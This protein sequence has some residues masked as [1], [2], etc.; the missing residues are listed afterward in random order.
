MLHHTRLAAECLPRVG[1]AVGGVDVRLALA[2]VAEPG[3]LHDRSTGDGGPCR[4]E[5]AGV[6]DHSE[7]ADGEARL[8]EEPL[9]G[10]PVLHDGDGVWPGANQHA[11]AQP[12]QGR[13][14]RILELDRHHGALL[15]QPVDR[16]RVV[17]GGDEMHIG[18]CARRGGGIGFEHH[19]AVPHRARRDGEIPAQLAAAEDADGGGR[20]DRAQAHPGRVGSGQVGSGQVGGRCDDTAASC[21]SAR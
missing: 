17:V 21:R 4:G 9:L 16:R 20:G 19:R 8:A 11:A 14:G 12:L 6:V 18:H 5:V 7:R 15:G 13:G 3:G 1:Q 10:A 2:V